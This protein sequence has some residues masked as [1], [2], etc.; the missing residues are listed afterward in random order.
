MFPEHL[1]Q[2]LEIRQQKL[3]AAVHTMYYKLLAADAWPGPKLMEHGGKP[4][5]HNILAVLDLSGLVNENWARHDYERPVSEKLEYG[6]PCDNESIVESPEQQYQER[7]KSLPTQLQRGSHSRDQPNQSLPQVQEEAYWSGDIPQLSSR[8]A[9]GEHSL[10]APRRLHHVPAASSSDESHVST[11]ISQQHSQSLPS[12]SV[13]HLPLENA[14]SLPGAALLSMSTQAMD[15]GLS[16]KSTEW[17][18]G[19]SEDTVQQK[20]SVTTEGLGNL[21]GPCELDGLWQ[22]SRAEGIRQVTPSEDEEMMD[23]GHPTRFFK[24]GW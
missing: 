21:E 12:S 7:P 6:V 19:E 16:E 24:I 18:Y 15:W 3:E 8:S 22:S 14:G 17:W 20:G 10:T 23:R 1:V 2:A 11:A 4:L 5:I 13:Q 9:T